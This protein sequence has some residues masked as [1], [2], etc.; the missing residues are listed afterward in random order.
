MAALAL[1]HSPLVGPLTWSLVAEEMSQGGKRAVVPH[2]RNDETRPEPFWQQHGEIIAEAVQTLPPEEPMIFVGHSG[3]GL[4]LPSAA[5]RCGREIAGYIFVDAGL[6]AGDSCRFDLF[7]SPEEVEQFRGAAEEGYLP[8]WS[9]E[10]LREVIEEP[11]LRE[12]F[13]EELAPTPVAL[14]EEIIPVLNTW[15][16]APCGYLR[17]SDF[18]LL[19][20]AQARRAGWVVEEIPGG[21]FEMLNRPGEVARVLVKMAEKWGLNLQTGVRKTSRKF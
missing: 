9:A 12:R 14:Y 5:E 6:P 15:P 19:S 1:I 20:L 4:L 7:G 8:V 3:A 10:D 16:D 21:H 2:L 17:F 11:V 18:Y 13:V